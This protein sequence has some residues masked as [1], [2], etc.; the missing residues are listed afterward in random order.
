MTVR[1]RRARPEDAA[2]I[3][4]VYR[5]AAEQ[6]TLARTADE[7][8]DAYVAGFMAAAAAGLEVVAERDGAVVGDLHAARL[9]PRQFSRTLGELTIAVHP[10]HQGRGVGRRLFEEFLRIVREEMPDIERVELF[11]WADNAGAL[12]LYE[13]LGFRY[14]GRLPRRVRTDVGEWRD[15]VLYAWLR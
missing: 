12:R 13:S 5:A 7:V 9:T 14:E 1:V 10:A 11:A 8:D 15:D 3:R 2:A 6:G 4:E